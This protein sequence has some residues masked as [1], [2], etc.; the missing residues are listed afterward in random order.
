MY[1]CIY[2]YIYIH[3]HV[4]IY[5]YIY[6]SLSLSIYIY[7]YIYNCRPRDATRQ[8][9]QWRSAL[10]RRALAEATLRVMPIGMYEHS[11]IADLI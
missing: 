3:I 4:C 9:A 2:I 8:I 1:V 7:I 10:A 6:T 11:A 5:I